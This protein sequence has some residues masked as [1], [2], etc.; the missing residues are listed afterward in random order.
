[1]KVLLFMLSLCLN[2]GDL[3]LM[4]L[5]EFEEYIDYTINNEIPASLMKDLNMGII[6]TAE[7]KQENEYY[8]MGEY[9]NDELGNY[10]LLYYGSFKEILEDEPYDAWKEEI[11]STIKHEIIHHVEALAGDEKLAIKEELEELQNKQ[12]QNK[13]Q[14]SINPFKKLLILLNKN[15]PGKRKN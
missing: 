9:I 10:V 13:K 12:L 15:F 2:E 8:I 1:M 14:T 3:N 5:A 6:V 11:I 4:N 7:K